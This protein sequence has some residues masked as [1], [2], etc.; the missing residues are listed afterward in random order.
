M[1]LYIKNSQKYYSGGLAEFVPSPSLLTYSFLKNWFTG[2]G[3]L[4]KAMKLLNLPYEKIDTPIL[5]LENGELFV[6][7]EHEELTLYKKTILTYK[8]Q[9]N[10]NETP[11]LEISISKILNPICTINTLKII[12]VQSKWIANPKDTV[13]FANKLL[14]IPEPKKELDIK[15]IDEILKNKIWPEVIAIGLI[16]EFYNQLISRD[17][18]DNLSTVNKY[19]SSSIAKEDWF[20]HSIY[21]QE[22]VK[23]NKILFSEFME[24]YGIRADKDYELTCPRWNEIPDEIRKRIENSSNDR[25]EEKQILN[26]D[27]KLSE[28]IEAS[29]KLQLLRSEAKKEALVYIYLLRTKILEETKGVQNI[30]L[31]T[32]DEVLNGKIPNRKHSQEKINTKKTTRTLLTGKGLGASQGKAKGFSKNITDNYK[33]IPKGT[34]CIFPSASPQFSH[35]YPKCTGMIFSKGGQTSHGAIV[36]REFRIPA[37]IDNK[38]LGIQNGTEIEIDGTTGEWKLC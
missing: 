9:E 22:E 34:I 15:E 5:D 4:G 38:T 14:Q 36:A 29:I 24:K 17:A 28:I 30:D 27:K 21:D 12:L 32:R 6:N 20:F 13:R 33:E 8:R 1:K 37:I 25:D 2:N 11:E 7:L 35:Q 18:K 26:V 16:S 10:L 23:T 19:I 3:S 31:L